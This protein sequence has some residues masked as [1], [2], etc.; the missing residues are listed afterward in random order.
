MKPIISTAGKT[1]QLRYELPHRAYDSKIYPISAPNGSTIIIYGHETGVGVLWRGGRPLGKVAIPAPKL[2]SKPPPKVNGTSN[3]IMIIDSDDEATPTTPPPEAAVF[4][5]D[6]EELDPDHPYPSIVQHLRLSLDVDVL[7]IAVPQIPTVSTLR[8]ADTIPAIF[9]KK[10]VFTVTCADYSVRV[11]TLPLTPPSD[12]AKESRFSTKSQFGEEVTKVPNHVGHQSAPRGVTMTWTSRSESAF[13]DELGDEMDVD[14][15]EDG[16]VTPGRRRTGKKQSGRHADE[17]WDLLVASHSAEFGGVLKIWRFSLGETSVTCTSPTP[18]YQTLSLRKPASQIIFNSAQYPKRRHSQLLITDSTGIARIYDPFAVS[19]SNRQTPRAAGANPEA[20]SYVALFRSSFPKTKS[21]DSSPPN[22]AARK[23]ILDAA[24]VSDGHHIVALLGDGEWGIW[25]VERTGP[26]PPSDPSAFSI[27]GFVNT[28]ESSRSN[29]G[30]SSPKSSRNGRNSLVPMTPNTRRTKEESLFQGTSISS[31][32][33]NSGGVN[34][35]SL[36]SATGG[37]TEDSVIIWYGSEAFR[38]PNL[39]K[40]WSRT[41]SGSN[42]GSL[43][44]PGLSQL[45]GLALFGERITSVNQMDTKERDARMARPRDVLIST[46]HRL[47]IVV[48]TTQPL[49]RDLNAAF[50]KEQATEAEA[51]KTD[52]ALL[53]RGELDLGGMSRLLEDMEGSA[54][55]NGQR[56]MVLGGPR[57]VLFASSTS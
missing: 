51:R 48:Q 27:R 42:G 41:V 34:I 2:P 30:P 26:S 21:T 40:F 9:S 24:W 53:A 38:I 44:G 7:H 35:A 8:P 37:A 14:V 10:M 13:S 54:N 19:S 3:A 33:P 17:G 47:I 16:G 11:I 4:E 32:V 6:E 1:T 20:G 25:D 5:E 49:G 31:L 22:L 45:Q 50:A 52:Q 18:A 15:R 12:A 46:D 56:S 23:P 28:T 36:P 57:K 29:S 39:A 55:T 43:A